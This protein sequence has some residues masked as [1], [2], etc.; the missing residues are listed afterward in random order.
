MKTRSLSKSFR[1]ESQRSESLKEIRKNLEINDLKVNLLKNS[2][3]SNFYIS[4]EKS[5][6]PFE[7]VNKKCNDLNSSP[8]KQQIK[9]ILRKMLDIKKEN[10]RMSRNILKIHTNNNTKEK[11][12]IQLNEEMN[13]FKFKNK[14]IKEN[15]DDLTSVREKCEINRDGVI[16]FCNNLKKRYKS[17]MEIINKYEFSIKSLNEERES[18]VKTFE[19]LC[20]LKSNLK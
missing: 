1:K 16:E 12:I 10:L 20:E 8:D 17:F 15:L 14:F 13:H 18:I 11:I 4:K 7:E 5:K 2:T 9:N 19:N 3:A 6:F